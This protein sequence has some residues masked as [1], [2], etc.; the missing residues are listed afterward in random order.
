MAPDSP[1]LNRRMC[2]LLG[3][4]PSDVSARVLAALAKPTV[5]HSLP[6][7]DAINLAEDADDGT[8]FG[9]LLAEY[10]PE[11]GAGLG[12]FVGTTWRIG[13]TASSCT[14]RSVVIVY[15][16]LETALGDAG[17]DVSPGAALGAAVELHSAT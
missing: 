14:Q 17:V 13:I 9:Q 11:K 7:L 3:P 10:D 12:P 16:A 1:A 15:G 5:G 8:V 6:D 2:A 4:G